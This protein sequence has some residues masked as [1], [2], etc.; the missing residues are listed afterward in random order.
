MNNIIKTNRT[1]LIIIVHIFVIILILVLACINY[2]QSKLRDEF[3]NTLKAGYVYIGSDDYK[4]LSNANNL[5]DVIK[6]AYGDDFESLDKNSIYYDRLNFNVGLKENRNTEF[7]LDPKKQLLSVVDVSATGV[8]FCT[9]KMQVRSTSS[10]D[11]EAITTTS[12][13]IDGKVVEYYDF[14][15]V[16]FAKDSELRN[17]DSKMLKGIDIVYDK[18]TYNEGDILSDYKI[19]KVYYAN[20]ETEGDDVSII[21]NDDVEHDHSHDH[22]VEVATD[23]EIASMSQIPDEHTVEEKYEE[24]MKQIKNG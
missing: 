6:T 18:S 11:Y 17:Y 3:K 5:N 4:Y 12:T 2:K 21:R 16:K 13:I 14:G 9:E 23:S 7:S 10:F 8:D 20:G 22:T 19:V 15:R 1:R 24:M